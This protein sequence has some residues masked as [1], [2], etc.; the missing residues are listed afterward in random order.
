MTLA[1]HPVSK[2]SAGFIVIIPDESVEHFKQLVQRGTNLWPDAPPEIKEFADIVTNGEVY[3]DY[4]S[5][6]NKPRPE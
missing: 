5:Q 6:A 1:I 2:Q 4:F 3:Q